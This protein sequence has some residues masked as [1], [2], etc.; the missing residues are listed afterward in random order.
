[1]DSLEVNPFKSFL[2]FWV[3][4]SFQ[5]FQGYVSHFKGLWDILLILVVGKYLVILEH[6]M[7][8][9][10]LLGFRVSQS[11]QRFWLFRL[12]WGFLWVFVNSQIL[13]LFIL[14]GPFKSYDAFMGILFI[15]VVLGMCEDEQIQTEALNQSQSI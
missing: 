11:F 9:G 7:Y 12:I 10:H 14:I 8:F 2:S 5:K 1:M 4:L 13:G 15:F 6:S 3:L